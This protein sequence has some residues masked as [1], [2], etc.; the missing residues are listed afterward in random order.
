[1]FLEASDQKQL[2]YQERQLTQIQ[3]IFVEI[4]TCFECMSY[5]TVEIFYDKVIWN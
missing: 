5:I 4:L 3:L 2:G 1:M